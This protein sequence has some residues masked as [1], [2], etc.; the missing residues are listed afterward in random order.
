MLQF[1]LFRN[2]QDERNFIGSIFSPRQ[3]VSSIPQNP[4][5]GEFV[6]LTWKR[7]EGDEGGKETHNSFYDG[8]EE[9]FMVEA[10]KFIITHEP[11]IPRHNED[12]SNH[13]RKFPRGF[14][15]WSVLA[16]W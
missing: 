14:F 3:S 11:L 1:N 12:C 2:V 10:L 4:V 5:R 7:M 8:E 9:S 15:F 16:D 6:S 13:N